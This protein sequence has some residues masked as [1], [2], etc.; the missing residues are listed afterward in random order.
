LK[1]NRAK[2]A[3]LQEALTVANV[4]VPDAVARLAGPRARA[5][6]AASDVEQRRA[7]VRE[8]F[9]ELVM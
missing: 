8:L 4:G 5:V 6:W 9:R 3:E 1:V 7:V 2:R